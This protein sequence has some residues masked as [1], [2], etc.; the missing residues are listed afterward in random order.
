M[1]SLCC[2]LQQV[3]ATREQNAY[4]VE[5]LRQADD[6][7]VRLSQM[8]RGQRL[9]RVKSGER[10]LRQR[11]LQDVSSLPRT[12]PRAQAAAE[13]RAAAAE[14]RSMDAAADIDAAAR[15]AEAA[16]ALEA[17]LL[18]RREGALKQRERA[19]EEAERVLKEGQA[20]AVL[21]AQRATQGAQT[22]A[23]ELHVRAQAVRNSPVPCWQP[24]PPVCRLLS[25][26]GRMSVPDRCGQ[27]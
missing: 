12:P 14:E 7:V 13:A 8:S 4:L 1:I 11:L 19:I 16:R 23:A 18:A 6:L 26:A 21:R 15:A 5:R 22:Q 10:L 3:A 17:R 9:L 20:E 27:P 25:C 2:Y 24:L